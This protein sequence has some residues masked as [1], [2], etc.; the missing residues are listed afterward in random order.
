MEVLFWLAL[1]GIAFIVSCINQLLTR[2]SELYAGNTILR[3]ASHLFHLAHCVLIIPYV[4]TS[5]FIVFARWMN[6]RAEANRAYRKARLDAIRR[7]ELRATSADLDE[8]DNIE[9]LRYLNG[10]YNSS[11][12]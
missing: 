8:M 9:R 2:A 6:E 3:I 1:I 10:E 11:N 12:K 7:G 4:I 5:L